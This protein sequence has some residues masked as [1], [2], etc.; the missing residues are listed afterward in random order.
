MRGVSNDDLVT[1]IRVGQDADEIAHRPA[2]H[3]QR[4]FPVETFGDQRFEPPDGWVLAQVIITNLGLGHGLAHR[5]GRRCRP[6]LTQVDD[7]SGARTV[8]GIILSSVRDPAV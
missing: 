6:V 8:H 5:L 7:A 1:M 2:R 3:K 4:G